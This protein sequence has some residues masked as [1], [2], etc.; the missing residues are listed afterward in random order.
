[1]NDVV[2]EWFRKAEGDWQTATLLWQSNHPV[3]DAVC[4]H[5]QQFDVVELELLNRGAV[6][7]RYPG[8]DATAQDAETCM[9]I[10][11]RLRD[12]ALRLLSN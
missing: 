4:F 7:F 10:C 8:R 11:T 3:Y 6:E 1:M 12:R 9:D 5:A 2:Q